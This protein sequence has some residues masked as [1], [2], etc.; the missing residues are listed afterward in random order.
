M[1]ILKNIV[2]IFFFFFSLVVYSQDSAIV[3]N[4]K[5]VSFGEELSYKGNHTYQ[6]KRFINNALALAFWQVF[7][8]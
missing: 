8:S 2:I 7:G 5:E 3:G 4:W 6:Y 1:L